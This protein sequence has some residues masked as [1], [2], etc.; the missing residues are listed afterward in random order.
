MTRKFATRWITRY[1]DSYAGYL[2]TAAIET[3]AESRP[4]ELWNREKAFG[5]YRAEFI[6]TFPQHHDPTVGGRHAPLTTRP[7]GVASIYAMA[8]RR[9]PFL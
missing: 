5:L 4:Q 1:P 6:D 7:S 3:A 2:L 9:L 8:T